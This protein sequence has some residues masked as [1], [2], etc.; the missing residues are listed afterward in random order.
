MRYREHFLLQ[1]KQRYFS[2]RDVAA[3]NIVFAISITINAWKIRHDF[4]DL[5]TF[6]FYA[7]FKAGGRDES[8]E[9]QNMVKLRKGS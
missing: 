1:I 7:I 9:Q 3:L 2:T 5:P 4:F 8:C 6:Y